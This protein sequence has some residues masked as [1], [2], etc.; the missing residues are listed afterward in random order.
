MKD[1]F[2]V[3][4]I[5]HSS[6]CKGYEGALK[7]IL[8][9]DDDDFGTLSFENAESLEDFSEKIKTM[10]DGVYKDRNLVVLLDLPGGSPAN[11]SLPFIN[12]SRKFIAG[13]N[14]PF[15][16]E[17]MAMKKNGISWEELNIEEICENALEIVKAKTGVEAGDTVILTAGIPSPH[18]GGFDYGVSNMMRIVTVD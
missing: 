10:I 6:L 7:L 8:D 15:V 18:V 3:L 14:L 9:I 11:V 5:T 12:S 2:D 13:I 17:L 16:L 1:A 4:M